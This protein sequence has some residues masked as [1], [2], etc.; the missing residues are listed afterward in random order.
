ML[1][2][3]AVVVDLVSEDNPVVGFGDTGGLLHDLGGQPDF[4][5]DQAAA[6]GLAPGPPHLLHRVGVFDGHIRVG[7]GQA[8]NHGALGLSLGQV[9]GNLCEL[10]L[11]EHN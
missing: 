8:R 2:D 9:I 4:T 10:F 3:R 1:N 6:G 5:A 11:S 7:G